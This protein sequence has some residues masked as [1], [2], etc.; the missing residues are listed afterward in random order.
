MKCLGI[1]INDILSIS[2]LSNKYP[3]EIKYIPIFA[4]LFSL[5]LENVEG[6]KLLEVSSND[7][8]KFEYSIPIPNHT[9]SWAIYQKL[10]GDDGNAKFYKFQNQQINSSLYAQVSIPLIDEYKTFAPS[11]VLLEPQVNRYNNSISMIDNHSNHTNTNNL[12]F[13]ILENYRILLKADYQGSASSSIF[14]EPFTQTSYWERQEI[15]TQLQN[16]GTYY[17]AV[18]NENNASI[19]EGKFV[20][21]VGEV[22]DFS[23]LD[24][25]ILIPYS[26]I[27]LKLFFDDYLSVFIATIIFISLVLILFM[28]LKIVQRKK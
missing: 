10:G 2:Y 11:L 1:T 16:L 14:Y 17:I 28:T 5:V 6:H 12:P 13:E 15:R 20:L 24:F 9:I 21:A 18:Y 26:W 4:I 22:E 23:L 25:F 8:I 27:K 7:N 3:F 19:T